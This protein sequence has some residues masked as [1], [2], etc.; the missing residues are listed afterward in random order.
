MRI[1]SK[2]DQSNYSRRHNVEFFL[3]CGCVMLLLRWAG[4]TAAQQK[5]QHAHI[6]YY[7]SR[8]LRWCRMYQHICIGETLYVKPNLSSGWPSAIKKNF[9]ILWMVI[10]V[11]RLE[12][13]VTVYTRAVSNIAASGETQVA[14]F[15]CVLV[16]FFRSVFLL[17]NLIVKIY[18]VNMVTYCLQRF[19]FDIF[20]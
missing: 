15:S 4:S 14:I 16:C 20:L 12:I 2:L 18:S 10:G 9:V 1:C 5:F 11:S 13:S 6:L 7:Q 8:C 19:I 17:V 3:M